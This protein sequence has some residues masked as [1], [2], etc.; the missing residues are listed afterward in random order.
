MTGVGL[1]VS[2]GDVTVRI[3]AAQDR[4]DAFIAFTPP[5]S[6]RRIVR[7]GLPEW[8]VRSEADLAVSGESSYAFT[9]APAA[10]HAAPAAPRRGRVPTKR[11]AR[12]TLAWTRYSAASVGL[13][14][15]GGREFRFEAA[16]G[17][18][19]AAWLLGLSAPVFVRAFERRSE[20]TAALGGDGRTS[21]VPDVAASL[22]ARRAAQQR[23]LHALV[24]AGV[25]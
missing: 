17:A 4:P 22:A 24:Q 1:A 11:L 2:L 9:E 25:I 18:G 6:W 19:D 20:V 12:P 14:P 23:Q 3:E 10:L 13:E 15:V 7:D 5:E 21:F 16:P 8:V